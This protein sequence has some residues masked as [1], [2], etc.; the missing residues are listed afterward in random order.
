MYEQPPQPL[1]CP[2]SHKNPLLQSSS[3]SPPPPSSPPSTMDGFTLTNSQY[4][5]N[6][7]RPDDDLDFDDPVQTSFSLQNTDFNRAL[8]I[9]QTINVPEN[10]EFQDSKFE[11]VLKLSDLQ[12]DPNSP[13][14]SI[15]KFEELGLLVNCFPTRY[16]PYLHFPIV[17][18][19]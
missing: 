6:N 3:S 17:G 11:V 8:T 19:N 15:K 13:L 10:Q 16:F 14:Y 1:H 9:N 2:N 12:G 5:G 4:A 18:F 7:P